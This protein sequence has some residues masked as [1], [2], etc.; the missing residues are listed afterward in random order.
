MNHGEIVSFLWGVADGNPEPDPELRDTESVPLPAGD[1]PADAEGV[2]A[3][4][5]SFFDR[6]VKP[7]VPDAWIYTARRDLKDGRAG[8][9]GYGINYKRLEPEAGDLVCSAC[10]AAKERIGSDVTEE[11][12][13]EPA[14]VFVNE[15]ER[16]KYACRHCE[17]G[18][19]QAE[20]PARPIEKGRPGPSLLAHVVVS[21]YSEHLPLHRLETI[22]L[23]SGV[24]HS[25]DTPITVQDRGHPGGSRRGY[26]WVYGGQPGD[27]VYDFTPSR[28]RAGPLGFLGDWRGYF[29]ADAYSGY[30]ALFETGQVIE[31]GAG[32]GTEPDEPEQV[33]PEDPLV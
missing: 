18:V 17:A 19:V 30:D 29:R 14:V 20:L 22:L 11:L 33:P 25:D 3:R 13:Y 27:L 26:M 5:R 28:A 10:S 32:L 2:P 8:L 9:I 15:Y 24:I 4:V 6:E 31:V 21:K 23:G 1:D 7:H 12:E 16:P